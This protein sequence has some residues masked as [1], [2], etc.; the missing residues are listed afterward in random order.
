MGGMI[1]FGLITQVKP[2]IESVGKKY[3]MNVTETKSLDKLALGI[4][5]SG[6]ILAVVIAVLGR[7]LNQD[8]TMIAYAA[9]A[10]LEVIALVLGVVSRAE[11]LGKAS[12]IASGILL[13]GSVFLA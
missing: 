11:P 13:V 2:Y 5:I 6:V 12:L 9:F 3:E 1:A 4:C 8:Y 7:V 10:G